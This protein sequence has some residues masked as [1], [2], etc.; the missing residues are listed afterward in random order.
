MLT[1]KMLVSRDAV[2]TAFPGIDESGYED[3]VEDLLLSELEDHYAHRDEVTRFDLDVRVHDGDTRV[4]LEGDLDG[5]DYT[6]E[7]DAL[8]SLYLETMGT[9]AAIRATAALCEIPDPVEAGR[10]AAQSVNG[11][12]L[13]GITPEADDAE[14]AANFDEYVSEEVP[15]GLVGSERDRWMVAYCRAAAEE[16]RALYA[17]RRA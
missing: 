12:V 16:A 17:A 11:D 10:R 13:A 9:D 15:R 8:K 6:E 14:E 7:T 4:V 2:C 3:L 1:I 5:I